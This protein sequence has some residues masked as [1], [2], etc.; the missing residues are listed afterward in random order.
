[1]LY[2]DG[3]AF[4]KH[5]LPPILAPSTGEPAHISDSDDFK[6]VLSATTHEFWGAL[7]AQPNY[8]QMIAQPAAAVSDLFFHLLSYSATAETSSEESPDDV[9]ELRHPDAARLV[10][11][12]KQLKVAA[13]HC[14]FPRSSP[15]ETGT[16]TPTRI[17]PPADEAAGHS[18]SLSTDTGAAAAAAAAAGTA[19]NKH[20]P[21]CTQPSS[22]TLELLAEVVEAAQ[23]LQAAACTHPPPTQ[24]SAAGGVNS[25][26][27]A[28]AKPA[29]APAAG[30]ML[31]SSPAANPAAGDSGATSRSSSRSSSGRRSFVLLRRMTLA[32]LQVLHREAGADCRQAVEKV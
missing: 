31:S 8:E 10:A 29:S 17:L 16:Q 7:L 11:T 12:L 26:S 23:R 13:S 32:V 28:A 5:Q 30:S 22:A 9:D 27:P 1:M 6:S 18:T 15:H 25:S 2:K 20:G 4:R 3:S 21:C 19:A 24:A 14:L